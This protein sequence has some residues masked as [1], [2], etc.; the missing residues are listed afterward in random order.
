VRRKISGFRL[1]R[2]LDGGDRHRAELPRE[3]E[4]SSS[5]GRWESQLETTARRK[6]R[7]SR[8]RERPA[9]PQMDQE[10]DGEV[11]RQALEIPRRDD[12]P[13][14]CARTRLRRVFQNACSLRT[15]PYRRPV[16]G[17][18]FSTPAPAPSRLL[19]REAEPSRENFA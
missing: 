18:D 3:A 13:S 19:R 15:P 14:R 9:R 6:P 17:E 7:R 10:P 2:L 11:R 8:S 5:A 1:S 4:L 12:S 16:F